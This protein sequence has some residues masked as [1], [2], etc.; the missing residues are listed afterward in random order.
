MV[1]TQPKT[2]ATRDPTKFPTSQLALLALVRVAEPIALTSIFPYAWQL[3]IDF[4]VGDRAN[5]SFYAG[6]LISAFALAESLTGMYD[7]LCKS[8]AVHNTR[9]L[10]IFSYRFWG[11]LSDRLGRKP[12]LIMGSFGVVA[13]LLVVGFAPSFW[14]ALFG[15]FLGGALNGNIGVIQ[16]VVAEIVTNPKHEPKAYA[17]MPFVWSIGVTI[18]PSIG[19]YFATPSN[20]FPGTP[21]D[22]ELF[23][24]FPYLLPNLLCA[25]LMVV[26][27]LA[28]WLCLE[29]THPE[30]RPNT[31]SSLVT[32][33]RTP[34]QSR[35]PR[36]SM[37]ITGPMSMPAVDLTHP[38]SYGTFTRVSEEAVEEEWNVRPDG[39]TRLPNE[40]ETSGSKWLTRRVAMLMVALGLFTY[41][42]MTYDHLMPIFFQDER[43]PAGAPTMSTSIGT[44][45]GSLAGG[46]GLTIQ[47]CGIILAFNGLIAILIQ[48]IVFPL[49]AS[50]CSIWRIFIV[51]TVLA[52]I[53]YFLVPWL[54]LLPEN[55]LYTGIYAALFVRNLLSILAYPVLL[56]LIKEA[57]PSNRL[58]KI[59]GLASSTG[60]AC[61]TLASP[62][63][64]LLYGVGVRIEFTALAWWASALVAVVGAVQAVTTI[65]QARSGPQHEVRPV[66]RCAF[67]PELEEGRVRKESVVR[68][69]VGEDSGYATEDDDELTPF[70][71]RVP[72]G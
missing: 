69:R 40:S 11:G 23:R 42:S 5:A 70:A 10:T 60:A 9:R 30:M 12:V 62:I 36:T 27:I 31:T 2:T 24:K 52:P 1:L 28:G 43:I 72:R 21:L 53:A 22:N 32:D 19:G 67:I 16:T 64:G 54:A 8:S 3:V 20:N 71:T 47:Q 58:G 63:A 25:S 57:S 56:I 6:L 51:V 46:L 44:Q 13:S 45:Y 35:T 18:G 29:E 68:I 41:H 55:L 26:S 49:V 33:E 15:R 39:S 59:N 65:H 50:L 37:L 14:V 48:G 61:R 4:N 17:I 34:I 7:N 66:G 38:E